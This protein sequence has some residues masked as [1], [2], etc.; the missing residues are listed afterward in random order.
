LSA[1]CH[2]LFFAQIL[3]VYRYMWSSGV[4]A[5][6]IITSPFGIANPQENRVNI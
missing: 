2:S 1:N 5:T 3:N 6:G 4:C